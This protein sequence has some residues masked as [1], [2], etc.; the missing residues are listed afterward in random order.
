MLK[1]PDRI[2]FSLCHICITFLLTILKSIL[3]EQK[4]SPNSSS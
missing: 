1:S 4:K 3:I 2:L